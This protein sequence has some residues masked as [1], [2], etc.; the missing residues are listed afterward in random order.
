MHSKNKPDIKLNSRVR[1][2]YLCY[3]CYAFITAH[4]LGIL[5]MLN[6]LHLLH[7]LHTFYMLSICDSTLVKYITHVISVTHM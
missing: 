1:T 5:Y 2:C 4:M 3:T 6:M 7:M